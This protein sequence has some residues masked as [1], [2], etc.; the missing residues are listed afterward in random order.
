MK[1]QIL[2][3]T[4]ALIGRPNGRDFRLLKDFAGKLDCDG[5]EL[6]MYS[7]WYGKEKE[8]ADFLSENGI[9]TPSYHC[10]K[11]IGEGISKGGEEAE[12]A[13][14][15]F[16][17]NAEMARAI[18]AEKMVMHLWDSLTSDAHIERNIEAYKELRE[19]ADASGVKLL[20]ENV[21]C[22]QKT[23]MEHWCELREAYP[24]IEFVFDT[25]MA[26]FHGQL[27]LIYEKEYEWL[28]KEG[29]IAHY[30][31]NDYGGGI[32]DWTNMRVLPIGKGH[33]DFVRFLNFVKETA[34]EGSFTLESTAFD[35]KGNV[36]FKMLNDQIRYIREFEG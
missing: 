18:G 32:K 16:K 6:M 15:R 28:W 22:N 19:T 30:H 17:I 9:K 31:V 2:C 27:E 35:H 33:I 13:F 25:K 26:D 29:H 11:G 3:S 20:I 12:D 14:R 24:D 7:D 21:V 8:I 10:Q 23:P 36:D 4:G 34:Y 1:N 5:F